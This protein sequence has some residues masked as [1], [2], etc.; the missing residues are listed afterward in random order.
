LDFEVFPKFKGDR[1]REGSAVK[2]GL[3]LEQQQ[4]FTLLI[5]L[6][7]EDNPT[8]WLFEDKPN[9]TVLFYPEFSLA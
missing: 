5:P 8:F 2:I 7:N 1:K 9:A 3:V 6:A 4:K